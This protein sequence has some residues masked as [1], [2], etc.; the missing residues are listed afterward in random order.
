MPE[1]CRGGFRMI[2]LEPRPDKQRILDKIHY[3]VKQVC[4]NNA[5]GVII[6]FSVITPDLAVAVLL[7]FS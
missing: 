5:H 2:P 3:K 1:D 7:S 6:L 4:V